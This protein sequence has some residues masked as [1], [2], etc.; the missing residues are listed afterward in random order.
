MTIIST[1]GVRNL[2]NLCPTPL[3]NYFLKMKIKLRNSMMS[4]Y[5]FFNA[6]KNSFHFL[7]NYACVFAW[8]PMTE[9]DEPWM[10]MI[11]L[12]VI[13]FVWICIKR[14]V[15][16][17]INPARIGMIMKLPMLPDSEFLILVKKSMIYLVKQWELWNN[18]WKQGDWIQYQPKKQFLISI[19]I[20]QNV[21]LLWL[22]LFSHKSPQPCRNASSSIYF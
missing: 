21:N 14:E 17:I 3:T 15:R 9:D 13:C 19:H 6:F 22:W 2:H 7:D 5:V 11:T 12:D 10:L 20:I 8:A 18:C 4:T 16:A 1:S